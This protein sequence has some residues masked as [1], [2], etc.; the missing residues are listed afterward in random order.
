VAKPWHLTTTQ[1]TIVL[2]TSGA[3]AALG[4][5]VCG[6]LSDRFGRR[7]VFLATIVLFAAGTAAL[8]LTPEGS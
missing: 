7:P 2:L 8:A 1:S 6:A 3:G 4:S 5:F